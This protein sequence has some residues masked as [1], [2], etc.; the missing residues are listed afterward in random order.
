MPVNKS[1]VYCREKGKKIN[2]SRKREKK[3]IYL[4]Q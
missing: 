3:T 4:E 1:M 2:K